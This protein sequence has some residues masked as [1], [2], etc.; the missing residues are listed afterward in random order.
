MCKYYAI[1]YKGFE[2]LDFGIHE[3]TWNQSPTDAEGQL[4]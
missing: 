3:W 4:C 2:C 1:L